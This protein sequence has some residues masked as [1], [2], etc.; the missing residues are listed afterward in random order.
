MA[1]NAPLLLRTRAALIALLV[2]CALAAT[3]A[4]LSLARSP[5]A[6]T[7]SPVSAP[8]EPGVVVVAFRSGTSSAARRAALEHAGLRRTADSGEGFTTV[9]LPAG[10][11]VPAAVAALASQRSVAWAVP[12]YIA[13]AAALPAP[14]DPNDPGSSGQ[15]GGWQALQWNF[16]GDFGVDAPQAWANV[17][18]DGAPGGAGVIVAVLD[19]GI[20]YA[21]H[22]PYVRSPDFRASQ[23]VPGYDFVAHSPYAEDRN[24][25]GTQVAGTIARGDEQRHRRHRPRLRRQADAGARARLAGRRRRGRRSRAASTSRSTITRRSSTSASSSRPAPF[26]PRR[27]RS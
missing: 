25:H 10:I 2:M 6:V 18:A 1:L 7:A 16:A 5:T 14:F 17:A 27:S 20:A 4:L 12:D 19:T 8:Y 22:G 15:P 26:A 23:F 24:G 11:S 9:A 21:N 3:P 13:H